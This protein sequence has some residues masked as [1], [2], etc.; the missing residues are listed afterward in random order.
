MGRPTK[1]KDSLGKRKRGSKDIPKFPVHSISSMAKLTDDGDNREIPH[2]QTSTPSLI[3]KDTP[4]IHDANGGDTQAIPQSQTPTSPV[5]IEDTP[6]N[7][8]PH[9]AE[10][11]ETQAIPQSQTSIPSVAIEDTPLNCEAQPLEDNESDRTAEIGRQ[12]GFQFGR[13]DPILCEVMAETGEKN[14][15]Q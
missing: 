10:D 4:P 5:V 11:G 7:R 12:L 8:E 2:S 13:K 3:I 9:T 6:P 1:Q 14:I 15:P